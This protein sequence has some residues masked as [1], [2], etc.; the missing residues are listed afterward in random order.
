MELLYTPLAQDKYTVTIMS[1]TATVEQWKARLA[2]EYKHMTGELIYN[3]VHTEDPLGLASMISYIDCWFLE[4][5]NGEL[6]DDYFAGFYR[7]T[8]GTSSIE[9]RK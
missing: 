4:Y 6:V 8:T 5:D 3:E 2:D 7:R 1:D 9:I